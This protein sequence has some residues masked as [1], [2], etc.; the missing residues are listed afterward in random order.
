MASDGIGY[1]APENISLAWQHLFIRHDA[2]NLWL[3]K[4][5]EIFR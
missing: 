5:A 1:R 3:G 4:L 2:P